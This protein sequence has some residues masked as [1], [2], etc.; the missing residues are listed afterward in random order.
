MCCYCAGGLHS[1]KARHNPYMQK[2]IQIHHC[3]NLQ[4]SCL[5]ICSI[6][7]TAH[8]HTHSTT[9]MT[10]SLINTNFN[11]FVYFCSIYYYITPCLRN[12]TR[13][14][15]YK[16][17]EIKL[18]VLGPFDVFGWCKSLRVSSCGRQP[19][20]PCITTSKSQKTCNIFK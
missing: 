2:S 15:L 12:V 19:E 6:A 18:I 14:D 1:V 8:I 5:S 7:H 3:H 9:C 17:E 16:N 4:Q 20:P 13:S 10:K 11:K